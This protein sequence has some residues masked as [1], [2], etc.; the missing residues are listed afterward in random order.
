MR[1]LEEIVATERTIQRAHAIRHDEL[2][3]VLG[4]NQSYIP[5][6]VF[7]IY[8]QVEPVRGAFIASS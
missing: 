4:F 3:T 7:Q 2:L 1:R 8:L 5:N 6:H